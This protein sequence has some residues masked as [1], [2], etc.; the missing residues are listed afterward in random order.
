MF[1]TTAC[2]EWFW[3]LPLIGLVFM[4]GMMLF[5]CRAGHRTGFGE[6]GCCGHAPDGHDSG[7]TGERTKTSS[8]ISR[9]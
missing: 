9:S 1:V 2:P 4:A 5:L 6:K 8:D 7:H 3:I